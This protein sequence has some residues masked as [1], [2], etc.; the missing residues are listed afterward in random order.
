VT[1]FDMHPSGGIGLRTYQ[2]TTYYDD[3][4]IYTVSG[5]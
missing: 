3:V 1:D 5:S 2:S 4:R